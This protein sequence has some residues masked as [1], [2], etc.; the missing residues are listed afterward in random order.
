MTTHRYQIDDYLKR[1][2]LP[3]IRAQL[4]TYVREAN[5]QQ[6]SYESFLFHLLSVEVAERELKKKE[7]VRKKAQFPIEKNITSFRFEEAPF[8]PKRRFLEVADGHYIK[9]K[10]NVLFVGN[11][12]T[13]KT[14]L[15]IALGHLAIEQGYQ[16]GYYTAA[17]LSN[18][19]MEAQDEKRLL[20]IEKQWTHADLVI[21]DELGYIPYHPRAAELMFQFFSTRYERGSMIITSNREFSRWNEVFHDDQ[22]TAALLDRITHKA[23]LFPMN[24][25]SYRFKETYSS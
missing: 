21:I 18:E 2:R 17:R 11:S 20:Q 25:D 3:T 14:H 1:L 10:R 16:V 4:D 7:S 19:L 8:V 24:G 5:E 15:S 22:M 12:G 9:E 6:I 13:G 23:H